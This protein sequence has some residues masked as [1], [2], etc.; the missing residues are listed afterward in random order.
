V[1][2]DGL[3]TV[4]AA[5][6]EPHW[7]PDGLLA[8]IV[9]D[10]R[11][12]RVLMLGW[13]DREAWRATLASGL[14][15]FHSRSRGRLWRKGETSGHELR[16]VAAELDCDAD[17]VL[18]H[19]EAA[20]PTC[21]TG[22]RSCFDAGPKVA[23][24]TEATAST[25]ATAAQRQ[26]FAWLEALWATIER[27]AAERPAGSH[28][29]E[30]LTGGVDAAARK[31]TEEA[32]E[33]LL[34]AKDDAAAAAAGTDRATTRAAF[35]AELADLLDHALVLCAERGIPPAEALEVLQ[36]RHRP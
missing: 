35:V 3:A 1:T 9:Q 11:D 33:V 2:A 8:G 29:A 16:L 32:T 30:L 26:G 24:P 17:A 36:A 20:G 15:H 7:G 4:I 27:R 31:V 18:L 21:H 22:A 25:A 13:L 14:V 23:G 6:P 5:S 28:T 34:A 12:G 19:V 10:A